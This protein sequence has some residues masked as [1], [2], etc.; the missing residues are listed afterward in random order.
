ME[1]E[2]LAVFSQ[3]G[4]TEVFK[5]DGETKKEFLVVPSLTAGILL[6]F[7]NF[8]LSMISELGLKSAYIFS[9]GAIGLALSYQFIMMLKVKQETGNYWSVNFSNLFEKSD[10]KYGIRVKW[11]N[12]FGLILRTLVNFMFQVSIILGFK[13]AGLAGM[14]QGIITALFSTYCVFTTIIFFFL[15]QE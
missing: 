2:S 11:T 5:E 7:N 6:G 8:F 9:L 14:N 1:E 15:F 12:V 10:S 3:F 13:Y 4:S